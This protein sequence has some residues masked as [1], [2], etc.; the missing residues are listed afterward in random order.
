MSSRARLREV[1]SASDAGSMSY[2]I[3]VTEGLKKA[4]QEKSHQAHDPLEV[5]LFI[6]RKQ[7]MDDEQ[8]GLTSASGAVS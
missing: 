5:G 7:T 6:I 8:D 3:D 4:A 2:I 1:P